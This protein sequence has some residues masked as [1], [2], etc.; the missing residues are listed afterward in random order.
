MT[1][2]KTKSVAQQFVPVS[3]TVDAMRVPP[4][5]E[6]EEEQW[7]IIIDWVR[8]SGGAAE[9][10]NIGYSSL[11]GLPQ[12]TIKIASAVED[13]FAFPGDWIVRTQRGFIAMNLNAFAMQY[14]T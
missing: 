2:R 7:Q 11:T 1:K 6:E 3:L 10:R 5:G 12:Y 13:T 4:H 14:T 8:D 9:R